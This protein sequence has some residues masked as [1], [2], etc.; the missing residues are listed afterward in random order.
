MPK[1]RGRPK[2]NED[3]ADGDASAPPPK[4]PKPASRRGRDDEAEGANAIADTL[5]SKKAKAVSKKSR[6][7]QDLD[8][9]PE[10]ETESLKVKKG[11]GKGKIADTKELN[12]IAALKEESSGHDAAP[13]TPRGRKQPTQKTAGL[14]EF[15][16]ASEEGGTGPE[17]GAFENKPKSQKVRK[18]PNAADVVVK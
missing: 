1:K 10:P 12:D 9:E 13:P 6:K 15:Q 3:A 8:A 17:S 7:A 5:P 14:Q 11:R 4:R 16:S 18:K 2:K